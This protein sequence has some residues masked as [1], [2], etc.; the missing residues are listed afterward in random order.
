M[1]RGGNRHTVIAMSIS[2][3]TGHGRDD[4]RE[5]FQEAVLIGGTQMAELIGRDRTRN[6]GE[7]SLIQ[8]VTRTDRQLEA[9]YD[10]P[11]AVMYCVSSLP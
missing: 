10:R 8:L 1:P 6:N 4:A 11:Q 7:A 5:S 9:I 3:A 2:S